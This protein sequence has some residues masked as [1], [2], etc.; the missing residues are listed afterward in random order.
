MGSFDI[1]LQTSASLCLRARS[2]CA[3]DE[4]HG[5]TESRSHEED[6]QEQIQGDMTLMK[7]GIGRIIHGEL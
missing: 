3:A 5:V 2:V 7:N 4:P 6:E 1:D